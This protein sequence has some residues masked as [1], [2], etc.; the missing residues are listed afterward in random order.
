MASTARKTTAS[1]KKTTAKNTKKKSAGKNVPQ[2]RYDSEMRREVWL[3]LILA[4]AAILALSNFG[5]CGAFGKV[6]SDIMFGIFGWMAYIFPFYL[7]LGT[8]FLISN[9]FRG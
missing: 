6:V 1:S 9:E 2:E 4:I 3:L 5:V 8:A 7:F